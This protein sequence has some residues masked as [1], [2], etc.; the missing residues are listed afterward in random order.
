MT[1]RIWIL[2]VLLCAV[3]GLPLV[4]A[5]MSGPLI[6]PD[7]IGGGQGTGAKEHSRTLKVAKDSE[8]VTLVTNSVVVNDANGVERPISIRLILGAM[9]WTQ[10]VCALESFV[11]DRVRRYV[12]TYPNAI[13]N[14]DI[15]RTRPDQRLVRELNRALSVG[16]IRQIDF[17]HVRAEARW[18]TDKVYVCTA[19]KV[20]IVRS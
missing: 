19:G 11:L 15:S 10:P 18:L 6:L 17:Y 16:A 2:V 9:E 8:P 5:N 1:V 14:P 20:R 12:M 4:L 7:F 13:P 3:I